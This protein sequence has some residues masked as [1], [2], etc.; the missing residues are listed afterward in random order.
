MPRGNRRAQFGE[1]NRAQ[2][3]QHQEKA[4]QE[5]RVTDAVD[6]ERL[7]PRIRRRFAQEVETDQQVAA[8]SH[9]FPADEQQ[10]QIVRQ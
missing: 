5:A 4:Q 1:L 7:L 8:Q 6:D 9:A 10:Q 3:A 2:R